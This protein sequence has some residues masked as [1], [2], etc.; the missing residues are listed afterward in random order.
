MLTQVAKFNKHFALEIW[1]VNNSVCQLVLELTAKDST[2]RTI[3]VLTDTVELMGW[4]YKRATLL[5]NP[6]LNLRISDGQPQIA[7]ERGN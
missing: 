5:W 6:I 4:A 2:S 7:P 1:P 3:F